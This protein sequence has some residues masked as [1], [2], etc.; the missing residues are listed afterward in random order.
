MRPKPLSHLRSAAC[1]VRRAWR[2]SIVSHIV[3]NFFAQELE[4]GVLQQ[5]QQQ[6]YR[7]LVLAQS[8]PLLPEQLRAFDG[9]NVVKVAAHLTAVAEQNVWRETLLGHTFVVNAAGP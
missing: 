2:I 1:L 5:H 4:L 8:L 9:A 7:F 6:T 3:S